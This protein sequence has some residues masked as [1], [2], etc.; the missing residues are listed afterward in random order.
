MSFKAMKF[1]VNN[2]EHSKNVQDTL[3][4]L[5]YS[6]SLG[7]KDYKHLGAKYFCTSAH[8]GQMEWIEGEYYFF[9]HAAEEIDVSWLD[10]E[11]HKRET[12][13]IHGK[14]FYRDDFE[15]AINS[16]QEVL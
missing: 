5:G 3:F 1:R 4:R 10:P 14:T 9:N 11:Q 8:K 6:W 12:I 16:L 13:T 2:P 15:E 7:V